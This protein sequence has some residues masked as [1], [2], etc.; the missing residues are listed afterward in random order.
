[1]VPSLGTPPF[2][3]LMRVQASENVRCGFVRVK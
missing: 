3:L 2:F 1:M